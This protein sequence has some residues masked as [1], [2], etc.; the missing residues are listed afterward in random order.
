[1]RSTPPMS[2]RSLSPDHN[3]GSARIMTSSSRPL[4]LA[5]LGDQCIMSSGSRLPPSLAKQGHTS[6]PPPPPLQP[7]PPPPWLC[8]TRRRSHEGK[9]SFWSHVPKRDSY[10]SSD[11]LVYFVVTAVHLEV[12]VCM[13]VCVWGGGGGGCAAGP[14]RPNVW[15][16]E[17]QESSHGGWPVPCS[18]VGR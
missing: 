12:C 18:A 9:H 3:R 4:Q 1:M 7:P 2:L 15:H 16:S 11:Q 5:A 6:S 14:V 13:C 10:G 17:A 8:L